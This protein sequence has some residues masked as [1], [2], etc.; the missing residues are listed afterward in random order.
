M[1][2]NG[3]AKFRGR[4]KESPYQIAKEASRVNLFIFLSKPIAVACWC[5]LIAQNFRTAYQRP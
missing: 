4:L 1:F 5:F 2:A 3:L